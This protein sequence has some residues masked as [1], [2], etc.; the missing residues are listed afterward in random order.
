MSKHTTVS[1]TFKT[2]FT[3]LSYFFTS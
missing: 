2:E 1:E 3:Q